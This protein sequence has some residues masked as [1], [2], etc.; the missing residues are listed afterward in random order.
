LGIAKGALS[1]LFELKSTH[2]L[3]GSACQLGRQTIHVDKEQLIA[4]AEKFGFGRLTSKIAAAKSVDDGTVFNALGYDTVESLDYSDF[5]NATHVLD[6]NKPLVE[7]FHGKYDLVFDG[8]TIEHIFDLPESLRNIFRLLKPGG[9]VVHSA[10]SSNHVDHGFYMFS[11]TLFH[12]WYTV[13]GF[14][15]LKSYIIE[16]GMGHPNGRWTVYKYQPECIDYLSFA[17]LGS[18]RLGIWFVARKLQ[19]SICDVIPQQGSYLK[20]WRHAER[21]S[22]AR[23][24]ESSITRQLK[25]FIRRY[26][27]LHMLA[28][29][30]RVEYRRVFRSMPPVIAR[31]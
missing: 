21:V 4:I 14:E 31:Y 26:R 27:Y 23:V 19:H 10:P 28:S 20:I 17:G 1:L 13:N 29:A 16:Y 25:E 24:P 5:E 6:F 22:G 30:C 9:L 18:K 3:A 2:E 15:I 8:G 7:K 11:P 12:D